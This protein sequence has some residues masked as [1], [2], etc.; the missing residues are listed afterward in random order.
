MLEDEVVVAVVVQDAT[1]GQVGATSDDQIRRRQAMMADSREFPLRVQSDPFD[2]VVNRKARQLLETTHQ[3]PV[4]GARS[5]R[6]T[7]LEQERQANGKPPLLD[8]SQHG[9]LPIRL[10]AAEQQTR[11]G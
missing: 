7:G 5:S 3:L 2:R 8:P 6:V 9:L 4:I 10:D 11:P 1:A